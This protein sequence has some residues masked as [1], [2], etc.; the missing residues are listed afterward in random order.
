M[1]FTYLSS[2]ST[3]FSIESMPF[4]MAIGI[5]FINDVALVMLMPPK[6]GIALVYL[7]WF[8]MVFVACLLLVEFNKY[9][10]CAIFSVPLPFVAAFLHDY[11]WQ[12]R[13]QPADDHYV[14]LE[15]GADNQ[16]HSSD[17]K[18]NQLFDYIF[19]SSSGIVNAGG[20]TAAIFGHYMVGAAS[21]VGF[22]FFFTVTL[23][24]YLMMA[25]TVRSEVFTRHARILSILLKF[26]VV[27]T[28]IA[29][30]IH[31]GS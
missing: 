2:I 21:A 28:L 19:D 20:M 10:G 22:C 27:G 17:E 26:L 5:F 15:R 25:T 23:G 7:S 31:V 12:Q 6:W 11:L 18:D 4:L 16:N 9:Y 3:S 29:T 13:Q 8:L 30:W 14:D 24:L 1:F